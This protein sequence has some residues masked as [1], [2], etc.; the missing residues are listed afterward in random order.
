MG[1]SAEEAHCAL[2]FSLRR[3]T[4]ATTSTRP[5]RRWRG[6][7]GAGDDGPL[8]AV[9]VV[10]PGLPAAHPGVRGVMKPSRADC[11]GLI[12][13]SKAL[14]LGAQ[15]TMGSVT[16]LR[17]AAS[18]G[19]SAAGSPSS[20]SGACPPTGR[21]PSCALP[22]VLAQQA[23]LRFPLPVRKRVR[24]HRVGPA[25]VPRCVPAGPGVRITAL[26]G[27][28]TRCVRR[29]CERACEDGGAGDAADG[30]ADSG[31][32]RGDQLLDSGVEQQR[33][34]GLG[35][36]ELAALGHRHRL[37]QG[38]GHHLSASS[39]AP[40]AAGRRCELGAEPGH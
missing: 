28:G 29:H 7:R 40:R 25:R 16:S 22:Q 3:D 12:G 30:L 5:S 10:A 26:R 8:P 2:R 17:F 19:R 38:E 33:R 6:P 11:A 24:V 31:E 20:G 37:A 4:T 18:R 27:P 15:S 23:T 13:C 21:A 34:H 36:L 1:R 35:I 32:D 9:Q 14:Q 39:P